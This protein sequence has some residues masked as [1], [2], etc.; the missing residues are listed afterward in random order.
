MSSGV[1]IRAAG[2]LGQ[3]EHLDQQPVDVAAGHGRRGEHARAQAQLLRD[4]AALALEVELVAARE[5]PLVEHERG[6]AARLHRELGDPQVLRGHARA[7]VAD[8]ERD[9]GALRRAL[10]AEHR[11]VLDGLLDLGLAADA[12]GVDEAQAAAVDLELGVD[13]V[14]RGARDVGDDHALA[15]EEGVDERGLAHVR[16]ADHREADEVL[17]LGRARRRRAGAARRAG[18]AGRRCPGPAPR[19][20]PSGRRARAR[21]SRARAGGRP[22][23]RSCWPRGPRAARRG[24]GCRRPPRRR[25][26]CPARAS[27]TRSATC[28]SASA[29]R[30][31]SWI[32]T[33]SGS[34][35]PR[36]TPPVSI[37]V[38]VR[39]FQSVWSSLRSRV[40]P[41]RSCTT[42][43]RD[44]VSRLTSDDFPTFG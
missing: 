34:S 26:A 12:R 42:A 27:T 36:S 29:A 24:A 10:G 11:V 37:S 15:A 7:R 18:R 21:G 28:A 22:A 35:S 2:A 4:A 30:A 32:E 31:W 25:A 39:P 38:N 8:H 13:R 16:A 23:S 33:E 19:R 40:T 3:R 5:V 9:V 43:S 1:G 41:G 14:A 6:R 44:C 20:P 17:V